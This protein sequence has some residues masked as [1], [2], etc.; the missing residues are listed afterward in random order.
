MLSGTIGASDS[1]VA[2]Q[3]RVSERKQADRV[4]RTLGHLAARWV[5]DFSERTPLLTLDVVPTGKAGAF[6]VV[7]DG[8][9]LA[10]AKFELIAESGWKKELQTDEQGAVTI[11]L[12][13]R[14]TYVI[15][16][17]HVDDKAGGEGAGAYHRK[18]FVT[19]LSFRTAQGLEGPPAPPLVVP[20]RAMA[21]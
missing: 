9:P 18:R 19:S 4:V 17:E 3:A 10:K 11:A 20:K 6:R 1:V 14:G 8:K 2:E 15:E 7:Y 5:P 21:E 13:W 12:P 16:I